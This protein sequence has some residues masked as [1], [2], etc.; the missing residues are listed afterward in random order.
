VLH[1]GVTNDLK[2]RIYEHREKLTPGFTK[3]YNATRL[4]YYE[5]TDEVNAAIARGKQIKGG[6]RA[7]KL[8]LIRAINPHWFDY[9]ESYEGRD[10]FVAALL[11]MT[12]RSRLDSLRRRC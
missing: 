5:V 1:T 10:C 2:R 12:R 3:R 7:K 11:A 8:G 9:I 6:S 4:V